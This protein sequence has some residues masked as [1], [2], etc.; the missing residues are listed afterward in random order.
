[1]FIWTGTI[2]S[3][4]IIMGFNALRVDILPTIQNVEVSEPVVEYDFGGQ[5]TFRATINSP[6]PIEQVLLHYQLEGEA[7]TEAGPVSLF[8][9]GRVV[10]IFD[11]SKGGLRAFSTINYWYEIILEDGSSI[12]SPEFSF[13]YQDNRFEW[14]SLEQGN[15]KVHWYSGDLSFGQE[16]L[17]IALQ[18]LHSALGY[19]PTLPPQNIDIYIYD[20]AEDLQSLLRQLE[21]SLVAG[22]ADPALN[23]IL[24]SLP[25]GPDQSMHMEQRIPHEIMHILTYQ[26]VG[27]TYS[28]LPVW[29][30]EGLASITELHPNLDYQKL[31]QEAYQHNSLIPI[32]SLCQIFPMDASGA[33]LAYA[34]SAAFTQYLHDQFGTAGIMNLLS[35][36]KTGSG[37]EQGV[38]HAF[39]AKLSRLENQWKRDSFA[40]R[41]WL[42]S[43]EEVIPWFML[44]IAVLFAPIVLTIRN[45]LK[46]A[47]NIS[48]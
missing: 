45:L 20:H 36:Y 21:R 47:E 6:E 26:T 38:E 34:Q 31:L 44:L 24:V 35:Q 11:A 23:L 39:N 22:H 16:V 30:N 33:L 32:T 3:I 10:S 18:G 42:L 7:A 1:M 43:I 41:S 4:A 14:Q 28:N 40:G 48:E 17:A 37:C 27:E 9:Q 13:Y 25:P 19:V 46:G 12:T 2:L 5:V 15:F 8:S 29:L